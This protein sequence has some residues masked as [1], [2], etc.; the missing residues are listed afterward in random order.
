MKLIGISGLIGD[1]KGTVGDLL[2]QYYGFTKLSFADSLKD[3]VATV[4]SWP[5]PLLEGDTVDSRVWRDTPD[6]W[7]SNRLNM[8]NL[9]P[10]IVLQQWGTEVCRRSFHDDIWIASLEYKINEYQNSKI[11]TNIVIPDTRFPNEIDMIRRMGGEVWQVSRGERPLWFKDYIERD[12]LPNGIHQSEWAWAKS[13]F[14]QIIKNDGTL[15]DLKEKI[16]NLIGG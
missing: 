9:T 16:K 11:T 5:R 12:I 14:D 7:W 4:F 6:E 15:D 1:G 2:E 10:R 13:H 3:A 8:P